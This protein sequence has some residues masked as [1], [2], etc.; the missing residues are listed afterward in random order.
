MNEGI[1]STKIGLKGIP[2]MAESIQI[3]RDLEILNYTGGKLH[4]P[5][6]STA[7]GLDLIIKAKKQGLNVSSSVGLPHLIFDDS[8]LENIDSILN[9]SDQNS[10]HRI[11]FR[12]LRVAEPCF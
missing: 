8:Q 1:T 4:L 2:S 10:R 12:P 6:I 9:I 7:A 3:A 11:I 5:N